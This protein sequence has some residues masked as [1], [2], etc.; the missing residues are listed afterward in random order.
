MGYEEIQQLETSFA[1]LVSEARNYLKKHAED[2]CDKQLLRDIPELKCE[3][4]RSVQGYPKLRTTLRF[5]WKSGV[6]DRHIDIVFQPDGIKHEEII[7][8]RL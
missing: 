2:N 5:E 7:W 1:A 6:V 8:R 3:G 4:F